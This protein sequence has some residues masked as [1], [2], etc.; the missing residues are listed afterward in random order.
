MQ[1]SKERR[2]SLEIV[3]KNEGRTL[4]EEI[5]R[6]GA[7][8]MLATAIEDEVAEFIE[9][10]RMLLDKEGRQLVVR[11]GYM[12]ERQIM[13]G[14]G[15]IKIRQPRIDDRGIR[16]NAYGKTFSS[17]ILP[18]YM[19]RIASIDNL[20][21][22]LY[23]KGISS[24]DFGT[25]LSAILGD[26][27]KGLSAATIMR[28][29]ASWESEYKDWQ[30][31][32]LSNKKY[33]YFWVDGIYFNVR[34]EEAKSCVLVIIGADE[35]GNKELVALNDGMRESTLSWKEL[36]LNLKRRGLKIGP[37]LA[38]GDGAMGFWAALEEVYPATRQQR[39]WVHK[40][41]NILDKMPKSIH[42]KVKIAIR[43][44][45]MAETKKDALKALDQFVSLYGDKYPKAVEC[46]LKD[47]EHL[48]AFY[49]FPAI[50]WIHL[51]TTNPIES[52]F[53]TVRHRTNRTRGCGS[54]AT[55]LAM[56]FKLI[57]EAEKTWKKL[58]GNNLLSHVMNNVPFVNGIMNLAA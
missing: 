43:E 28:L 44:M 13:T 15:D 3:E 35:H 5:I 46:L 30:Q 49:D 10:H 12:P 7:Q 56:A 21:P 47:K 24:G 53:A 52:T 17:L 39:C 54:R 41:V 29:K 45:Y 2:K 36:L 14:I 33:V 38:V 32:S 19:R 22:V 9:A 42:G 18:K 40:T 4:L 51:R 16:D 8:E 37:K 34:L 11:N 57:L 27:A 48:F 6:K 1:N 50:Q 20:L 23:L 26:K 25:A 55:I 58:K 31:R